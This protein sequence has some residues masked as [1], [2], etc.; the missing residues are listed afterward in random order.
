MLIE[1]PRAHAKIDVTGWDLDHLADLLGTLRGDQMIEAHRDATDEEIAALTSDDIEG[2]L[3]TGVYPASFLICDE[4]IVK[5]TERLGEIVHAA[6]DQR[7]LP[8]ALAKLSDENNR[9]E[10]TASERVAYANYVDSLDLDGL[11]EL[12]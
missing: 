9:E 1:D 10:L 5:A 4:A 7:D 3:R 8:R 6:L 11:R 2:L 12:L